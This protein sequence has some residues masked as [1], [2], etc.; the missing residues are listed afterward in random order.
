MKSPLASPGVV[1]AAAREWKEVVLST[2]TSMG[3]TKRL[4][5]AT[6]S[7]SASRASLALGARALR[8]RA[9]EDVGRKQPASHCVHIIG[10]PNRGE[11]ERD[12]EPWRLAAGRGR[13]GPPLPSSRDE[14]GM[15]RRRAGI[16]QA[17]RR[18]PVNLIS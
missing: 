4:F 5:K 3:T 2:A 8:R 18:H 7:S 15:I 16:E 1:S 6:R 17:P 11:R 14:G 10:L 12:R 9:A 13:A